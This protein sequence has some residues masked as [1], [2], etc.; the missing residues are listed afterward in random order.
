MTKGVMM[1]KIVHL[2]SET[3]PQ[4]MPRPEI[5]HEW[6]SYSATTPDQTLERLQ[7]ADVAVTNKVVI[8]AE[9]MAK[10]PKLKL[11]AVTATGLNNVDLDAA[12]AHN[13]TV[14]NVAGYSSVCV[15][16]HVLGM[17]FALKHSLMGWY[18]DQLTDRWVNHNQFC[19]F[20][21]PLTDV[22]GSTLAIFGKG[23]LGSEVARLAEAVG[24]KVIFAEHRGVTEC[25]EGYTPFEQALAQADFISLHCPLT[26]NTQNLINAETLALMKKGAY[27]INTGRGPLVDEQALVD[28]LSSGHLAGAAIDVMI[29]EPPQKGNV[30]MEAAK[31]MPNL[32]ITPHIAWAADSAVTILVNKVKQNIE[33][34]AQSLAK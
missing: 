30:L 6:I 33:A 15:P 34:F 21:Y 18:R 26:P 8:N 16:E 9:L 32:L 24:M 7:D 17:I 28:A 13:I 3:L 25:R 29:Q 5:E 14:K 11:I 2:D 1:L 12:K 27:L 22:R 20:D 31:V 19:Y 10:L 23:N 4:T